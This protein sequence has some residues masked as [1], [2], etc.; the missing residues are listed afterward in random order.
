MNKNELAEKIAIKS[1]LTKKD[2]LKVIE[3]I[4]E[5]ILESLESEEVKIAGFGTFK[6]KSHKERKGINPITKEE[7]L[8]HNYQSISFKP[9]KGVKKGFN[10]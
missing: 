5:T 3:D 1:R 10:D 2:S 7:I 8:I 4:F 6:L 9:S